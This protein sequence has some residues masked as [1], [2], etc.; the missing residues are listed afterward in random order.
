MR[1][2][3]I[4]AAASVALVLAL[5]AAAGAHVTVH[6]DSV[7]AGSETELVVRVPN[8]RDDASTTKVAV[9][10]PHGFVGAQFAQV[11]GWRAHTLTARLARPIQTDDGPI[12]TEVRQVVWTAVTGGEAGT[13]AIPPGGYGDFPLA[14]LIPD[15][16]GTLTFKALQTYSDGQ[17]VRWIGP[18]SAEEPAPHV[19]V[20][21]AAGDDDHHATAPATTA[22]EDG[23]SDDGGGASKGLG[24]AALVVAILGLLA[25]GL[26][27]GRTRARSVG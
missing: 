11:P 16:P 27:L 7:A 1:R 10:L 20:T 2:R 14:V 3:L 4:L 21:P 15:R 24:I 6:P 25:G 13:G 5:P 9:Q 8:E 18:E 22:H 17:V 26:A 12:A 23:G 19:T